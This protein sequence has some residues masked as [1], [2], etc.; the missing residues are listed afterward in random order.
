MAIVLTDRAEQEL[1]ENTYAGESV[2]VGLYFETGGDVVDFD[3]DSQHEYANKVDGAPQDQWGSAANE[4]GRVDIPYDTEPDGPS[5]ERDTV[6]VSQANIR[7]GSGL[8]VSTDL[9][10]KIRLPPVE[11]DVSDSG[12]PV[13]AVF[14]VYEPTGD[15]HFNTYLD[16]TYLLQGIDE[17]V[18]ISNV[19]L[20][21]E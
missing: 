9:S 18:T 5:Y 19:E 10:S 12:T 15:V 13:N 11:F 1:L 3:D 16:Q 7:R 17:T 20:I 2:S 21:I 6:T 8:S 4:N 14:V